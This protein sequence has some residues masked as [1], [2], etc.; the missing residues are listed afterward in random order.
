MFNVVVTG[1]NKGIGYEI[2]RQLVGRSSTHV[3]L[4]SRDRPRGEN[5]IEQIK[6]SEQFGSKSK[7]SLLLLDLDDSKS[8]EDAAKTVESQFGLVDILVNNGARAVW[9]TDFNADIVR[10]T[11]NTNFFG[12]KLT[13]EKFLPL[14]RPG[15]RIVNLSSMVSQFSFRQ[16]S[17]SIRSKFLA[18]DLTMDGLVSSLEEYCLRVEKGDWKEKGW[19]TNGYG[20]SKVG[21]S[22]LTRIYARDNPDLLINCCCP[23]SVKTAMNRK[24]TKTVAEGA[25]TPL[26]LAIG[27]LQGI[28][29]KFWSNLLVEDWF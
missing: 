1:G 18:D 20:I 15:G 27:D 2:C 16:M 19:P 17:E 26:H 25:A 5:A 3:V 7:I 6:K 21:V 11:L 4:C 12:L 29:G 13:S 8:I 23:G 24:G 22:M 10:T 28:S 9:G 14:I